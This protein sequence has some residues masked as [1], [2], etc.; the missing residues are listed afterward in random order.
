MNSSKPILGLSA[1]VVIFR[2]A[3]VFSSVAFGICFVSTVQAAHIVGTELEL[4]MAPGSGGNGNAVVAQAMVQAWNQYT[5]DHGNLP[6]RLRRLLSVAVPRRVRRLAH[7][8]S[9]PVTSDSNA[10]DARLARYVFLDFPGEVPA[11]A[12]LQALQSEPQ[13]ESV[14]VSYIESTYPD[15]PLLGSPGGF[16]DPTSYQWGNSLTGAPGCL[17]LDDGQRLGRRARHW[18]RR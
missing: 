9:L 11:G 7:A 6:N 17:G 2:S 3:F 5:I 13:V 16:E 1:T 18:Y 12:L 14:H 4:R 15:D 8:D 10:I